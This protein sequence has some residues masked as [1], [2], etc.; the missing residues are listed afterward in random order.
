MKRKISERLIDFHINRLTKE[1]LALTEQQAKHR[2]KIAEGCDDKHIHR[3]I[4]VVGGMILKA[5]HDLK[6][7]LKHKEGMRSE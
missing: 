2:A 6:T 1:I 5:D 4:K 3:F 7:W